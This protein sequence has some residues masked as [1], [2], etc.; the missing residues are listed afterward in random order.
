MAAFRG[1]VRYMSDEEL[2]YNPMDKKRCAPFVNKSGLFSGAFRA[3]FSMKD[4]IPL[5]HGP[6]GCNFAC[7][8]ISTCLYCPPYTETLG[9]NVLWDEKGLVFGNENNLEEAIV[10]VSQAYK[11]GGIIVVATNTSGTIGEDIPG[12]ISRV[13]KSLGIPILALTDCVDFASLHQE[14]GE[15]LVLVSII[16][17][18]MEPPP[19]IYEKS[20][21]LMVWIDWKGIHPGG[22]LDEFKRLIEKM[23]IKVNLIIPAGNSLQDLIHEAPKAALNVLITGDHEAVGKAMQ[24][25]FGTPYIHVL[26]PY[27]LKLTKEAL[28]AIAGYFG[29]EEKASQVIEE[30]EKEALQ[31]VKEYLP[32][33][34]GLRVGVQNFGSETHAQALA[35]GELGLKVEVISFTRVSDYSLMETK[36]VCEWGN[37]DPEV[38]VQATV[39][40]YDEMLATHNFDLLFGT[41]EGNGPRV[42]DRVGACYNPEHEA[43]AVMGYRG[44]VKMAKDLAYLVSH[45][46]GYKFRRYLPGR[47]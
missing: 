44:F 22:N 14:G 16:K 8:T 5:A 37:M 17:E 41:W 1:K 46:F 19:E 21:N 9:P 28:L 10:A 31:A 45:G 2:N 42:T 47:D 35:L 7:K 4:I 6:M 24:E 25:R 30:E 13:G 18:L 40:E 34:Q 26:Q 27:G 38:F 29:M 43:E 15:N 39:P 12:V 32:F 11:P 20:V 23:G 33:I 3:I 36:R